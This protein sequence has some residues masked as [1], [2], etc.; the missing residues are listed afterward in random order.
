MS[1]V[2]DPRVCS[3]EAALRVIGEKWSLLVVRELML[4]C[5]KYAEI[6]HNTGVPRDI[7]TRR[8][9]SLERSGV[10]YRHLYNEQPPRYDYR[11][12]EAGEQLH[13][14]LVMMRHWGDVYVRNDPEYTATVWHDCT[15][16]LTPELR[17][18]GCGEIVRAGS[19]TPDRELR[20]SELSAGVDTGPDPDAD[21]SAPR[22]LAAVFGEPLHVS[23]TP[24]GVPRGSA[25][26][27]QHCG[28]HEAN[29]SR[30]N[31][32]AGHS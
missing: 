10:I 22:S 3:I 4:G 6:V 21:S 24:V 26:G 28:C 14:L 16:K 2:P 5:T 12:A 23:E 7:L 25:P 13:G 31:G 1:S 27:G 15:A 9:R 17:C 20:R 29:S 30:S 11:L 8:L 32:S 19:V 18:A